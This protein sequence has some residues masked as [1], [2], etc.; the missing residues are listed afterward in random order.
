MNICGVSY[1]MTCREQ[2][3]ELILQPSEL[4]NAV[5]GYGMM[6]LTLRWSYQGNTTLLARDINEMV[7]NAA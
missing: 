1:S 4:R 2:L 3:N 6:S 7:R 5:T